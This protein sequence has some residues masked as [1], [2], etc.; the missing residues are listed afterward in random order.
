MSTDA[1]ILISDANLSKAWAKALLHVSQGRRRCPPIMITIGDC[2]NQSPLEDAAFRLAVDAELARLDKYSVDVTAMTIFPFKP[3]VRRG[4]PNY[5]EFTPFCLKR[6]LPRLKSLNKANQKGTYFERMMAFTGIN[7][8][9]VREVDQIGFVIELL[10]KPR[11]SRESALQIACFDPAKDHTGQAVRGFPCLQQVSVSYDDEDGIAVNG[12]YPTQ[13][14]FDRAYGNY[15]GL[16]HLGLFLAHAADLKF[17]RLSCFI[18]KP[19]LGSVSKGGLE[20]L[21]NLSSSLIN[22]AKPTLKK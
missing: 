18:G 19:E 9:G 12:Y 3:W 6:F 7:R 11:R 15:L 21:I 17:R 14:I 2:H 20:S 4:K 1:P 5:K 22:G 10:R 16:C 13:Y 8:T